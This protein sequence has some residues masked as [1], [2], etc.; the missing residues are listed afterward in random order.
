LSGHQNVFLLINLGE[1]KD[2]RFQLVE[3]EGRVLGSPGATLRFV[4]KRFRQS[5]KGFW[6]Q[7]VK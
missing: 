4:K 6:Q 1:A 5:E 2:Q 7:P 3:P